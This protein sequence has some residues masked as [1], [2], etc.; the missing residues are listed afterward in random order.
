MP[1]LQ[2]DEM[3]FNKKLQYVQRSKEDVNVGKMVLVDWTAAIES[4]Y[5]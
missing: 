5:R 1:P 4:Y 3:W 2:Q